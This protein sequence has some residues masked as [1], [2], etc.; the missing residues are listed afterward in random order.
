MPTVVVLDAIAIFRIP[1]S[2]LITTFEDARYG[3]IFAKGGSVRN[4]VSIQ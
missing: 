3:I 4:S 2:L 1:V